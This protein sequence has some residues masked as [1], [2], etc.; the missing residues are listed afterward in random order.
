MRELS[1]FL[2]SDQRSVEPFPCG[3]RHLD[4]ELDSCILQHL[5]MGRTSVSFVL[6]R[7]HGQSDRAHLSIGAVQ[8][9][10]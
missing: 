5:S 4:R 1:G 9:D 8:D 10:L 6:H 7:G 2:A 3:R